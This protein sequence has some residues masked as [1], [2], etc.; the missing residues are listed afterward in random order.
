[1]KSIGQEVQKCTHCVYL[2]RLT[3]AHLL[4]GSPPFVNRCFRLRSRHT[5]SCSAVTVV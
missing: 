3:G 5:S 4:R 1:M 2:L